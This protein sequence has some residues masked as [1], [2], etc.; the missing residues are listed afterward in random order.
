MS[1]GSYLYNGSVSGRQIPFPSL[2]DTA[3]VI[4]YR[5]ASQPSKTHAAKVY[6]TSKAQVL[7]KWGEAGLYLHEA[8]E[9]PYYFDDTILDFYRY[10]PA[11]LT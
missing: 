5:Q 2:A 10:N 9:C 8:Y 6:R 7:S 3:S 1:D 4:F 11:Y